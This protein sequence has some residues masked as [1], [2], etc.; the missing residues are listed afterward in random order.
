[1]WK[2]Q[3]NSTIPTNLKREQQSMLWTRGPRSKHMCQQL[4]SRGPRRGMCSETICTGRND[5]DHGRTPRTTPLP[6]VFPRSLFMRLSLLWLVR[7]SIVIPSTS[8]FWLHLLSWTGPRNS[9][10]PLAEHPPYQ[11]SRPSPWAALD[12]I[13]CFQVPGQP[14]PHPTSPQFS[15][16]PGSLAWFGFASSSDLTLFLPFG[17]K[18]QG[19]RHQ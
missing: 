1:M 9:I 19:S 8:G 12:L 10:A 7:A 15:A 14:Q 13:P 18:I 11:S 2:R 17:K 5:V 16:G 3:K 4:G 6:C